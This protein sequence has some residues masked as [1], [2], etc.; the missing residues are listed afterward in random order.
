M[1]KLK[2]SINSESNLPIVEEK[3]EL[4]LEKSR[5]NNLGNFPLKKGLDTHSLSNKD[6][7]DQISKNEQKEKSS[8]PKYSKLGN[9][10]LNASIDY[11]GRV[12]LNHYIMIQQLGEGTFSKVYK[13][14]N[15]IEKKYYVKKFI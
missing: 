5:S 10:I 1:N 8:N 7:L 13:A 3:G 11:I 9:L 15:K 6:N 14:Y 2:F 4:R 12:H